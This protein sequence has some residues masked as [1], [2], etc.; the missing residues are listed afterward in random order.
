MDALMWWNRIGRK[1]NVVAAVL[2][3]IAIT[4]TISVLVLGLSLVVG[5]VFF[6]IAVIGLTLA[7]YVRKRLHQ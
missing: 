3:S 6:G 2:A 7:L 1:L 5:L 4:G